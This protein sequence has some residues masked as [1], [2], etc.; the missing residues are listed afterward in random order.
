MVTWPWTGHISSSIKDRILW[1]LLNCPPKESNKIATDGHLSEI[2]M[3]IV[4]SLCMG[5]NTQVYIY[6]KYHMRTHNKMNNLEFIYLIIE[7]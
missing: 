7:G 1:V 6:Y 3:T 5:M 4:L 2:K